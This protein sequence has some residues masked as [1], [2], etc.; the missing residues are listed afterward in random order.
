MAPDHT[1]PLGES[2]RAWA[3]LAVGVL[4]VTAHSALSIGVSVLMKPMLADFA[5]ARS[6]FAFT[7]TARML[8]MIAVVPFA[9]QL[10]TALLI[11]AL[12]PVVRLRRHAAAA[13]D[14]GFTRRRRAV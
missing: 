7:M 13:V 14:A 6:D 9:G 5:W 12:V 8:A 11:C 3:A 10:T 1:G 2:R 4:A